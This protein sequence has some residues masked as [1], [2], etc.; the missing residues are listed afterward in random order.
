MLL[1]YKFLSVI[2]INVKKLE[3]SYSTGSISFCM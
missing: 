1:K 3:K 2:L